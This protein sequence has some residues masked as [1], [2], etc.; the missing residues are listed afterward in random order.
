MESKLAHTACGTE[1]SIRGV[2]EDHVEV[3][4]DNK[5]NGRE[6]FGDHLEGIVLRIG[7]RRDAEVMANHEKEHGESVEHDDQCGDSLGWVE[8]QHAASVIEVEQLVNESLTCFEVRWFAAEELFH[9]GAWILLYGEVN[10]VR[11]H[12]STNR[13]KNQSSHETPESN[14]F[15]VQRKSPFSKGTCSPGEGCFFI[16]HGFSF[17]F[18]GTSPEIKLMS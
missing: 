4:E 3:C 10:C 14:S 18:D 16:N 11:G 5:L 7:L 1:L 8:V 6:D 2:D 17:C 15:D 12:K 13:Q 9:E